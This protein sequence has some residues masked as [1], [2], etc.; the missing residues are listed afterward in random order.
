MNFAQIQPGVIAVVAEPKVDMDAY[1]TVGPQIARNL[2][3]LQRLTAAIPNNSTLQDKLAELNALY[4]TYIPMQSNMLERGDIQSHGYVES[5]RLV[6]ARQAAVLV[7]NLS[8]Q[9][10]DWQTISQTA[11]DFH[12]S[13]WNLQPVI[14]QVQQTIAEQQ[15]KHHALRA[16]GMLHDELVKYGRTGKAITD[17]SVNKIIDD[18]V[19]KTGNTDKNSLLQ[20]WKS[21]K[22][23]LTPLQWAHQ[24]PDIH[25]K[26]IHNTPHHYILIEGDAAIED[27]VKTLKKHKEICFDTE[28]T[29]LDANQAAL[30]GLSFSVKPGEAWYVPCPEDAA[31]TVAVVSL[32]PSGNVIPLLNFQ[33]PSITPLLLGSPVVINWV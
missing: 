15:V 31:A 14:E 22:A 27:L 6:A 30:V 20:T 12:E 19:E 8:A 11:A 13:L 17:D 26:N 24:S 5:Q 29:G 7:D 4:A 33:L 21:S 16:V 3:E 28:T 23:G 10:P 18:V 9:N 25:D 32:D 1:A 2:A